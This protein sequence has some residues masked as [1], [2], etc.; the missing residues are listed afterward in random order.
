MTKKVHYQKV[1]APT[2]FITKDRQRV[3]Q[4]D[5]VVYLKNGD[6]FE[7]ELFNP[8]K[9][10]VLAKI[11]LND[12]DLDSGIILRPGERVFLERYLDD[13]RKFI[14]ETYDVDGND[15]NVKEAIKA[16]GKVEVNFYTVAKNLKIWYGNYYIP[17][18]KYDPSPPFFPGTT[19]Y[20]D[21]NIYWT[22]NENITLNSDNTYTYSC[23]SNSNVDGNSVTVNNVETGRVEKGSYSDQTFMYDDTEFASYPTWTSSWKILP[24][25]Q[26]VYTKKTLPEVYCTECG[27][28]RKKTSHKYCPICGE[29][30]N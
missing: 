5:N 10:K 30:Y 11:R 29:K 24:V 3:K 20:Q 27:A 18:V 28:K 1:T 7:L 2:L 16:N 25:S 14:F 12:Y 4:Y 26:K 19:P 9:D 15:L 6:E 21:P 8:T 13:A 23:S 17:P 22:S